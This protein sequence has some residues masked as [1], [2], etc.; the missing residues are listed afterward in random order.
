MAK[1]NILIV[2]DEKDILDLLEYHLVKEGYRIK[3]VMSGEEVMDCVRKNNPDLI[4]LDLMLPNMDGLEVCKILKADKSLSHI[5]IIMLTAKG[6]DADIAV[7]LEIGADDYIVK[8]FSPRV[9]VARVKSVMRRLEKVPHEVNTP[10]KR[11]KLLIH[12]GRH[13]VLVDDKPVTLTHSE[14]QVLYFL[15]DHPRWV[16][17]RSQIVNAIRGQD[18]PVTDRSI[19]VIIVG[20]RKKL[21]EFGDCI[22][23]VRG[24]GY[25]FQD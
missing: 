8:P 10:I 3:G 25:R 12:P 14:F 19:D 2:E 15:A 23:T 22:E 24:M 20:L 11:D 7:G 21:G 1:Y 18:Y 5:P 6:E 4:I 16:F 17:T 9:L 13:E